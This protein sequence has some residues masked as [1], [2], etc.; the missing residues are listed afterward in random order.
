M[1]RKWSAG[2]SAVGGD[3]VGGAGGH[4]DF[5]G[6]A[7]VAA[8]GGEVE[9]VVFGEFGGDEAGHGRF[10]TEGENAPE[11]FADGADAGGGGE[12][13]VAG[14]GLFAESGEQLVDPIPEDDGFVVGDEIGAAGGGRGRRVKGEG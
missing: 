5:W 8:G 13:E 4:G 2:L 6:V 10:A 14:D 12:G 11:G 7:E 3:E 9:P 1:A